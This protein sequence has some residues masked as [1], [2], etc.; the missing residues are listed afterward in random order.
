MNMKALTDDT[1]IIAMKE[2]MSPRQLLEELPITPQATETVLNTR[3]AI[4]KILRGEDDRLLVIAGPCS[5]HDIDAA[6]D[7]ASRLRKEIDRHKDDLC[8]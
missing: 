6:L 5:I 2:L 7:Y 8:V 4:Q 3:A 1:R